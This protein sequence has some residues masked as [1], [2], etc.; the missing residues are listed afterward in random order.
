MDLAAL[1]E[2]VPIGWTLV[3]FQGR[4]YGL[5]RVDHVGGRSVSIYAE[6]LGGPDVVSANV[7]RVSSGERLN[8]C[9]MPDAKVLAFLRGWKTSRAAAR[10]VGSRRLRSP[11]RRRR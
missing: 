10:T 1:V 4:P 11:R 9:E 5:T 2:R 3:E 8:A 7:Y 6:E